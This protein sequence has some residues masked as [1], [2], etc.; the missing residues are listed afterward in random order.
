MEW[1]FFV[2]H[3]GVSD[4]CKSLAGFEVSPQADGP[5]GF[6]SEP[7]LCAAVG[8]AN[9]GESPPSRTRTRW[10]LAGLL[11]GIAVAGAVAPAV[12]A[13]VA[14]QGT[15]VPCHYCTDAKMREAVVWRGPGTHYVADIAGGVLSRY[16]VS[17][18][19]GGQIQGVG[20]Q[21]SA[22]STAGAAAGG[23]DRVTGA[24]GG[25]VLLSY[26]TGPANVSPA[27]VEQAALDQFNVVR[28]IWIDT[29]GTFMKQVDFPFV[30]TGLFWTP[31]AG[32]LGGP[33][34]FN[35]TSDANFRGMLGTALAN[36]NPG[37]FE[38]LRLLGNFIA[39]MINAYAGQTDGLRVVIVVVF[40]DGSSATYVYQYGDFSAAYQ[41]GSARTPVG[42]LIPD[43]EV[44]NSPAGAGN[45]SELGPYGGQ[46]DLDRFLEYMRLRGV[47]IVRGHDSRIRSISCGW[48][49]RNLVC[50]TI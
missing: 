15:A 28:Q 2:H 21:E 19:T 29:G 13:Q 41:S 20:D 1:R 43:P 30:N 9:L 4:R 3:A 35:V 27:A 17:C 18:G 8:D 47:R 31:P 24:P 7:H 26:C 40:P 11:A 46:E 32:P 34:A 22:D 45:W 33:N 14:I 38:E 16:T 5:S 42:Q 50:T 25:A 39:A 10:R 49:G 23:L 48:D 37:G 6:S 36:N 12:N 44:A